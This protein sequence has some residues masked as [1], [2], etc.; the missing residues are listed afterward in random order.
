MN[1]WRASTFLLFILLCPTALVAQTDNA[2]PPVSTVFAVLTR[3]VESKSATVGQELILRTLSDVVV[4]GVVVIPKGAR[5]LG[6]VK[7]SRVKG[8]NGGLTALSIVM[9]RV[10]NK[11]ES[12]LPVQAIIAAVAAPRSNSLADDPT[13]GM[14]HS[15]EPNMVGSGTS[16]TTASGQLPA[17]S[18]AASTATV[19]TAEIKGGADGP[20]LLHKDA[21]GAVGYEGLSLQWEFAS[22]P[23][24][25]VFVSKGKNVELKAGTQM[26][27]RMTPPRLHQ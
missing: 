12:G 17:N 5:L 16:A 25:T 24:V 3:A 15:L 1:K 8:Q 20:L 21:Q 18:K 27:L 10:V 14:M 23:P 19:A 7:E 6:H 4:D 11:D 26:L 2:A 9:D 22:P 13:Y